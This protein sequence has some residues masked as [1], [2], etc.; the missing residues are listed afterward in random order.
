[1]K[2]IFALGFFFGS[3]LIV[4]G[5]LWLGYFLAPP[6]FLLNREALKLER[7]V[8]RNSDQLFPNLKDKK[9]FHYSGALA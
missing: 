5:L 1:M 3:I 4:F 7:G 9:T 6:E 2:T 8:L